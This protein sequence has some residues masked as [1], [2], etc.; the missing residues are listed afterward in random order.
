MEIDMMMDKML[1]IQ[2]EM[3]NLR[4]IVDCVCILKDSNEYC[5]NKSAIHLLM[6]TQRMNRIRLSFSL[7]KLN[8]W[9]ISIVVQIQIQTFFLQYSFIIWFQ[10]KVFFSVDWLIFLEG[11]FLPSNFVNINKKNFHSCFFSYLLSS[12]V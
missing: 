10:W 12:F 1:Q 9:T 6:K 7:F 11:N 8:L 2:H 5:A 4:F 3:W